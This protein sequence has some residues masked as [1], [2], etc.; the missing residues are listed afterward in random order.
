M[1]VYSHLRLGVYETCPRQYRFQYGDKVPVPEI[2]T[3]EMF[4]GGQ[5]HSALEDLYRPVTRGSV[6]PLAAVLKFFLAYAP[7]IS[8]SPQPICVPVGTA[9][10]QSRRGATCHSRGK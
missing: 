7:M 2:K 3:V 10:C 4:V 1:P 9:V 5:V 6:P 8:D